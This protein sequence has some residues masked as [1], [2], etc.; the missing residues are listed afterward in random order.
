MSRTLGTIFSPI[1]LTNFM[2]GTPKSTQFNMP[3]YL[4]GGI[5]FVLDFVLLVFYMN[6]KGDKHLHKK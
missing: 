4:N 5:R 6:I 3:F 2:N 1:P